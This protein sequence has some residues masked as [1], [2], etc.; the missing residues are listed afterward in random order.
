MYA[1]KK[2]KNINSC[3]TQ[4]FITTVGKLEMVIF[5]WSLN[6]SRQRLNGR[7]LTDNIFKCIFVNENVWIPIEISLKF[8]PKG[9]I[10]NIPALVHIMAWCSPGDKPL[11][12]P[13]M[14]SLLT[15]ISI[16][17]PQWFNKAW[18]MVLSICLGD[19]RQPWLTPQETITG[20]LYTCSH[21]RQWRVRLGGSQNTRTSCKKNTYYCDV[22]MSMMASQITILSI[23]YS[24]VCSDADQRK[25]QGS[26]SLAFVK[27]IHWWPVNFPHSEFPTHHA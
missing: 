23:V 22:I 12:E 10:N 5:S 19:R 11:S 25:H 13:M 26:A 1:E 4:D 15:H 17:W 24:T 2:K 16:T 18:V 9:P 27:G 21:S 14:V 20:S 6:T 7:H 8:V 3:V